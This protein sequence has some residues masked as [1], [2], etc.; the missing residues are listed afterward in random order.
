[1]HPLPLKHAVISIMKEHHITTANAPQ[2]ANDAAGMLRLP[3]TGHGA[4]HYYALRQAGLAQGSRQL[5]SAKAERWPHHL[6][7][8][9]CCLAYR[10][11]ALLQF[12]RNSAGAEER[13]IWMCF[14]VI[15][16]RVAGRN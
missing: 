11:S 5:R 8:F 3:V 9:A 7:A 14:G 1:M 10:F 13:Q 6:H 4:P 16:Y 12:L 15:S 2:P